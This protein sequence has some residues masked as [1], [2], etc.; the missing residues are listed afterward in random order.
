MADLKGS[1]ITW[2]GHAVVQITTPKGSEIL[3]DPFIENNPRYPKSHRLP[4]KLDLLLLT[5]GHSDHIA[6]AA[7]I[8]KKHGPEVVAMVELAG[9]LK[10]KGVDKA[11]GMNLGGSYKVKDVTVSMVEAR[12]SSGID[13]GGKSLYGGEPV[14]YVITIDGGPVLYHA[15]DTAAF[16]DMQLIRDLHAPEIAFLP[17]GDYY[18][19]GP[20]GAAIAAGYLG[21]RAVVPIHY[22]TFPVL[23]GTPEELERHLGT[24]GIEVLKVNPGEPLR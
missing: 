14:G 1:T 15:G 8:A 24:S 19:M 4:Q 21:V 12:H 17:I 7:S 16:L 20:K 3:I 23:T 22:G 13:D 18:T 6:D 5:H 9:W 10:S 11:S 2:L